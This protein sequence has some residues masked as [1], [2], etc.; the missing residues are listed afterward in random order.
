MKQIKII[1]LKNAEVLN[2]KQMKE[3]FGG[4]Q[5]SVN[6]GCSTTCSGAASVSTVCNNPYSCEA[7]INVGALCVSGSSVSSMSAYCSNYK[8]G[9]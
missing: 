3:I 1:Q 9:K 5:I 8:S 7:T 6:S 4:N 2:S